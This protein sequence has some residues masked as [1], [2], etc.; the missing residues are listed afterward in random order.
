MA[1][2]RNCQ[3]WSDSNMKKA[4]DAVRAGMSI[5]KAQ[6]EFLIPKETLSDRINGRWKST[7]PGRTTALFQEEE[8]ALIN[9]IKYMASTSMHVCFASD[10]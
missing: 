6:K 7:K 10:F 5:C 3:K 9:C 8:T 2:K 1:P 4:I